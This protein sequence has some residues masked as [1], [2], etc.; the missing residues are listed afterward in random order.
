MRH[1]KD[2]SSIGN[3]V[4]LPLWLQQGQ[5]IRRARRYA[6]TA[7]SLDSVPPSTPLPVVDLSA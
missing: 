7:L 1:G 6:I 2:T 4:P 5:L 3:I